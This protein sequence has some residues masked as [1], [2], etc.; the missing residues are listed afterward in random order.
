MLSNYQFFLVKQADGIATITINH[1]PANALS[2]S[3]LQ[4]LSSI[5]AEL[6][7]E[8]LVK[9]II[10]HGQGR[11]FAAGADIKEFTSLQTSAAAVDLAQSAQNVFER[12]EQ[13]PK[14]VIA[15]VYGAALGGGLELAMACHLRLVAKT[16]KLGL[17]EL[18]LGLIPGFAGSQRLPR[19][20][21]V[22]KATEM[23]LTSEPIL[24]TEAVTFGLANY[25]FDEEQLMEKAYELA[26]KLTKKSA[27]SMK[28]TLEVL[29]YRKN[30]S[31]EASVKK[32]AELF[33]SAFASEDAKEGITAFL[34][35]RQP[36][37]QDQ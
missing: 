36:K 28:L 6:E 35:K 27:I 29:S 31:F 7:K 19:Y 17:P 5:F 32:E 9:V 22:A 23:I 20:V 2:S 4:E 34:E 30:H 13:F 24:G 3:L 26:M 14:P 10:I 8:K 15:A 1:P 18:Q 37:F 21:G 16:A 25:A 33:G 12:I 11:F